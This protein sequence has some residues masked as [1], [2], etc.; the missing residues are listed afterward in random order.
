MYTNPKTSGYVRF[1]IG[2][3]LW[4]LQTIKASVYS[5]Q[6]YSDSSFSCSCI[7]SMW[8]GISYTSSGMDVVLFDVTRGLSIIVGVELPIDL[9]C[10]PLID[11]DIWC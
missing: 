5:L 1:S 9:V 8:F 6:A 3:H 11:A 4:F 10:A 2:G 7:D